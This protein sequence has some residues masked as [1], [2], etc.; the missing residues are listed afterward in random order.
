M[1]VVFCSLFAIFCLMGAFHYLK[2]KRIIDNIP[3][4]K[5]QSVALGLAELS[6]KIRATEPSIS[7]IFGETCAYYK[8]RIE[9]KSGKRTIKLFEA[10]SKN[11]FFLEDETGR[12]LV[13]PE[14]I[15]IECEPRFV[16][17]GSLNFLR[18][19]TDH[20]LRS[21]S[22]INATA[23]EWIFKDEDHVY[24]LGNVEPMEGANLVIRRSKNYP[25]FISNLGE[26]KVSKRLLING[27]ILLAFGAIFL[28]VA[29]GI[30]FGYIE[31]NN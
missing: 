22:T 29:V 24:I 4:S 5:V 7:P 12:I 21:L 30:L 23:K 15:S 16:R 26:K 1:E 3:T 17:V 27:L 20:K 11:F 10:E 19:S 13:D 18:S 14:G 6:G 28:I 2:T 25:F 31:P 9:K 8:S